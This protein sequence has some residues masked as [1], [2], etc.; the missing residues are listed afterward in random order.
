ML[1]MAVQDAVAASLLAPQGKKLVLDTHAAWV[2]DLDALLDGQ[3]WATEDV[4]GR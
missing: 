1:G 2:P 3:R 4:T